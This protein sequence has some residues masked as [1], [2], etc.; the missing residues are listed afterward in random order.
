[1][2]GTALHLYFENLAVEMRLDCN[3]SDH[4]NIVMDNPR[5]S[6]RIFVDATVRGHDP[7]HTAMAGKSRSLSAIPT[8]SFLKERTA[9]ALSSDLRV[10]RW[11]S[12]ESPSSNDICLSVPE[13]HWESTTTKVS[14]TVSSLSTAR[15][16]GTLSPALSLDSTTKTLRELPREGNCEERACRSRNKVMPRRSENAIRE[17]YC[18]RMGC[19]SFCPHDDEG[20]P[21]LKGY[22]YISRIE[23]HP[24]VVQ[25]RMPDD[26]K[27]LD[28]TAGDDEGEH[29]SETSSCCSDEPS[30]E[31]DSVTVSFVTFDRWQLSSPSCLKYDQPSTPPRK[32]AEMIWPEVSCEGHMFS[33]SISPRAL[34]DFPMASPLA[35]PGRSSFTRMA[36]DLRRVFEHR[37]LHC[38]LENGASTE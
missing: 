9:T 17:Q 14:P 22:P 6:L 3:I 24:S 13:R 21:T 1:M 38:I 2:S 36:P 12:T 30:Q 15:P 35:S 25:K 11:E 20:L 34:S 23:P 7:L 8:V 18:P 19:L 32:K 28:G 31:E 10:S 29:K 27:S 16:R 37:T 4:L 5:T 26:V 33:S